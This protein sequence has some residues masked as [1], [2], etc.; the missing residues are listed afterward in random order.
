MLCKILYGLTTTDLIPT[1]LV[2]AMTQ[3]LSE[4][5]QEST[6]DAIRIAIIAFSFAGH[7]VSP[8]EINF[9]ECLLGLSDHV[10][11]ARRLSPQM[12]IDLLVDVNAHTEANVFHAMLSS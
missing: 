6:D 7:N 12:A 1:Y 3:C 10:R 8:L 2:T 5:I 9:D 4:Q 11:V